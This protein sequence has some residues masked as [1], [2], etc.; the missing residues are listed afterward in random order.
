MD[1]NTKTQRNTLS[2][3]KHKLGQVF[4]LSIMNLETVDPTAI[5]WLTEG[6]RRLGSMDGFV[7]SLVSELAE[8][9]FDNHSEYRLNKAGFKLYLWIEADGRIRGY[10]HG[11]QRWDHPIA[12]KTITVFLNVHGILPD[13]RD[14]HDL[15]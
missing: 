10:V 11:D 6:V 3:A 2:V 8:A 7:D 15:P 9:G 13:D 14:P 12:Y 5:I 4:R 1:F